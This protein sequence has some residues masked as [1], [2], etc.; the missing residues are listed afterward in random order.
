MAKREVCPTC[1]GTGHVLVLNWSEKCLK[2]KA[3]G[4]VKP[5]QK[6]PADGVDS[7]DGSRQ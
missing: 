2:C 1:K 6:K 5:A 3:T 4:F 7:V